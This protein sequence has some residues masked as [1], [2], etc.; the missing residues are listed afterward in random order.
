[1]RTIK[2]LY[3]YITYIAKLVGVNGG[4]FNEGIEDENS[5]QWLHYSIPIVRKKL[6]KKPITQ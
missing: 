3:P 1:M 5:P 2:G 6:H 4:E